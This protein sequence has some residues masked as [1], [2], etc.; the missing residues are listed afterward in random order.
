MGGPEE[1]DTPLQRA[2]Y[3]AR[4]DAPPTLFLLR[5]RETQRNMQFAQL[6]R[7]Q[8]GRRI[9]HQVDRLLIHREGD[10]LADVG[11]VGQQHDD[12][13]DAG[14]GAAVWRSAITKGVQH[15]AESPLDLF[16][17]VA[18]DADG[19]EHDFRAMVA[20][21]ARAKLDAVADDVVLPGLDG[22]RS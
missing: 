4:S 11:L 6:L 9:H 18:C 2:D 15:A 7:R 21:G 14:R 5:W 20:D 1:H 8:L 22:E 3:S 13:I 12:T 17:A 10:D 19:L 16:A